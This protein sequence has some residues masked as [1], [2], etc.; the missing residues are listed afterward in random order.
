[1]PFLNLLLRCV[2]ALALVAGGVP[3]LAMAGAHDHQVAVETQSSGMAG[4]HDVED[5][6]VKPATS[7]STDADCCGGADCQCD[8][9]HHMPVVTILPQAM[10][11]PALT[12]PD[13]AASL[14]SRHGVV[15]ANPLRPPIA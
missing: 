8:C 3:S 12:A 2:L 13:P 9:L 14:P 7:A 15:A 5:V 10:D 1:M 11:I 4:C 6:E